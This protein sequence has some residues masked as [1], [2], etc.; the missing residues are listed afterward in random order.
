[1]KANSVMGLGQPIVNANRYQDGDKSMPTFISIMLES[2]YTTRN[3]L[4]C[5][6]TILSRIK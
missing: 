3:Y 5:D 6:V 1:M 2:W 4:I